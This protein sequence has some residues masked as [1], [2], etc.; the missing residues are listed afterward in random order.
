MPTP[1]P[2]L[3][4]ETVWAWGS[5]PAFNK[6][7]TWFLRTLRAERRWCQ[8]SQPGQLQKPRRWPQKRGWSLSKKTGLEIQVSLSISPWCAEA[9][10]I[11]SLRGERQRARTWLRRIFTQVRLLRWALCLASKRARSNMLFLLG[12]WL[13]CIS[14]FYLLLNGTWTSEEPEK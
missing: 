13:F 7:S 6:R 5:Q 12:D 14:T 10:W 3:I 1:G 8:S 11:L 4:T 2:L 9:A